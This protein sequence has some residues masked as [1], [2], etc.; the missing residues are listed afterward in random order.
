MA[1][2]LLAKVYSKAVW[3]KDQCDCMCCLFL[4]SG[5]TEGPSIQALALAA[6]K[7]G[8]S[9]SDIQELASLGNHG[10][11]PNHIAHQ[12]QSKYCESTDID[13]PMPY[14]VETPVQL[15]TADG[16]YVAQKKI[17]MF[18]PHEWFHWL[19]GQD[20]A[21]SGLQNV[22]EFWKEH[23]PKDPQLKNNIT[24]ETQQH[25]VPFVTAT[26]A[27][28]SKK[29]TF[30]SV[31]YMHWLRSTDISACPVAYMEMEANSSEMIAS[32]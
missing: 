5:C 2:Q 23:S 22:E 17:G 28:K 12:L 27:S 7:S 26:F 19:C 3:L 9:T 13:L 24:K 6:S 18:L 25:R 16:L 8:A 31:V 10:Q 1:C 21:M 11:N 15:R 14:F 30:S 29:A 20:Q 4:A 32:M